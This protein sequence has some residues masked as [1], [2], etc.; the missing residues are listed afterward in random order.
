MNKGKRQ[1]E[2]NNIKL[3]LVCWKEREMEREKER[4]I[5]RERKKGG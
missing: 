3:Y 2:L 5:N 1:C 4:W